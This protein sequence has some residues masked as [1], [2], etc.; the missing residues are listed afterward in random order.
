MIA[1][2]W[3]LIVALVLA[4]LVVY[5]YWHEERVQRTHA[6]AMRDSATTAR[7][8]WEQLYNEAEHE[9]SADRDRH[10]KAIERIDQRWATELTKVR[11]LHQQEQEALRAQHQTALEEMARLAQYGTRT[12]QPAVV[13]P[14]ESESAE[15]AALRHASEV[16]IEKGAQVVKAMYH[17]KGLHIT[18]EEARRQAESMLMLRSPVAPSGTG[19]A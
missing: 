13:D 1:V 9:R 11:Q 4:L 10:A 14:R 7:N 19:T 6:E 17:E 16:S 12:P 3:L 2:A 5:H 8:T 18:D 15:M